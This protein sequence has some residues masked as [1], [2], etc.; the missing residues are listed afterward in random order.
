MKTYS[1]PEVAKEV[2]GE[3]LDRPELWLLRLVKSGKVSA[4]RISRGRGIYRFS[5][6]QKEALY[7]FLDTADS[8]PSPTVEPAE[9][10]AIESTVRTL[11]LPPRSAR[12]LR[13]IGGAS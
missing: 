8:P 3:D 7:A 2:C 9:S 6:Q 1:L 5:D 12:A 13:S 10:T 4:L 11:P